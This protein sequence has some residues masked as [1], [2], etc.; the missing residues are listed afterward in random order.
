MLQ[1]YCTR[2]SALY[3]GL[4]CHHNRCEVKTVKV[5]CPVG[6]HIQ[7]T[8]NI[9]IYIT[10]CYCTVDITIVRIKEVTVVIIH[11]TN[12]FSSGFIVVKIWPD[13]P[14]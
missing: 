1:L 9:Y 14:Q 13:F 7:G 10:H 4:F 3:C 5:S 12:P 8:S 6:I 2:K 11:E